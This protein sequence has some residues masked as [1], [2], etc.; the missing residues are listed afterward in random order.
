MKRAFIADDGTVFDNERACRAYERIADAVAMVSRA[1][2]EELRAALQGRSVATVPLADA[3][4]I[5]GDQAKAER[6][7][8]GDRRRGGRGADADDVLVDVVGASVE[9][10]RGARDFKA[11]IPGK[12]P[13]DLQDD[14]AAAEQWLAEWDEASRAAFAAHEEKSWAA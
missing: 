13:D 12:I 9:L 3:L 2:S 14:R 10:P 1:T 7:D 11:G 6:L 8:A 5:L 4:E